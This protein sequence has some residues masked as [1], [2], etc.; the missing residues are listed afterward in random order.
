MPIPIDTLPF[1]ILELIS[2]S[3]YKLGP[4]IGSYSFDEPR[5]D[6][7]RLPIASWSSTNKCIRDASSPIVFQSIEARGEIQS[8]E[9]NLA[10]MRR[11]RGLREHTRWLQPLR[12]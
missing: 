4:N 12:C 10:L 8:I 6:V 2:E 5:L 1:D 11:H 3:V 9:H 7:P